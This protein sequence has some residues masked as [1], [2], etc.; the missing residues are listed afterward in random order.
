MASRL[1]QRDYQP[2][3]RRL[4]RSHVSSR[5]A[6][7]VRVKTSNRAVPIRIILILTLVLRQVFSW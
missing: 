1:D 2:L 3:H 5:S 7:S 4:E 6:A